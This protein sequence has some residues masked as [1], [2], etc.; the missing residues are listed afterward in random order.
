MIRT[1]I[2]DDHPLI[3]EGLKQIL[4]ET[5]DIRVAA[6]AGTS[7]DA[8]ALVQTQSWDVIVLDIHLPDGGGLDLL[9]Q[10]RALAPKTPVL[11]LSIH[12]D[13]AYAARFI[14]A[15]ASGYIGKQSAREHLVSAIR[16]VARGERYLSAEV[17]EDLA[18]TMF[19]K[20]H[21]KPHEQ[22]SDREFEIFL[23]I[24]EGK[25]PR[26][27]AEKLNLSTKTVATHRGRILEKMA[28]R[29]NAE[30]VQ[31]AMTHRLLVM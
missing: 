31:Y 10:I 7:A 13:T 8:V 23:L 11:M 5:G 6:E 12:E 16:K 4:S 1:L 14:R 18:F 21:R 17:A 29:N 19:A 9:E 15:G 26:E 27:I 3:R 22:L 24:A 28:L 2:V 20:E 30:L 25:A